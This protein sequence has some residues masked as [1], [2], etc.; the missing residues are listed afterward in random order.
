MGKSI[1]VREIQKLKIY[2]FGKT[3][4]FFQIVF[5]YLPTYVYREIFL[6]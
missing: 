5:W 1:S 2:Y 6:T 3:K 4:N